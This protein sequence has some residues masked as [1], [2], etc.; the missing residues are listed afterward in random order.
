LKVLRKERCGVDGRGRGCGGKGRG[1]YREGKVWLSSSDDQGRCEEPETETA[2]VVKGA[3]KAGD[4][5]GR[6]QTYVIAEA[7]VR[8]EC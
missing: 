5:K 6:R 8:K 2:G 7:V 3:S 1:L 4:I